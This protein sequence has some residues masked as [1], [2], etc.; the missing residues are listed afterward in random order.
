MS[1]PVK[2]L[3]L[4]LHRVRPV[5]EPSGPS[6]ATRAFCP[7]GPGDR[8]HQPGLARVPQLCRLPDPGRASDSLSKPHLPHLDSESHPLRALGERTC[9][10]HLAP[11]WPRPGHVPHRLRTP[12]PASPPRP[13]LSILSVQPGPEPPH[14]GQMKDPWSTKPFTDSRQCSQN[15]G[16]LLR[17]D[18][19]CSSPDSS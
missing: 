9:L 5:T 8:W 12:G 10:T 11:P 1:H 2:R 16:F 19:P 13:S 18:S 3:E 7:L 17:P 14:Q 6:T 4:L 15:A